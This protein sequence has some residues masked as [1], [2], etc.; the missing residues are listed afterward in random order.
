[1]ENLC[2]ICREG[3]TFFTRRKIANNEVVCEDCLK[4]AKNLSLKQIAF[5]KTVTADEIRD[6]IIQSNVNGDELL[7]FKATNSIGK[8]VQFDDDNKKWLIPSK[9]TFIPTPD[10]IFN[11]SDIVDFELLEDGESVASGGLG[12][13]LVGGA[14]FGGVG[15][16]VGGVTGKR[17]S[18]NVCSSLRLK[19]TIN[20]M[21]SPAVYINFIET[22]T[23]K[24]GLS[25]KAIADQAQE[26]LSVF[27]LI[28][29]KQK[30]TSENMNQTSSAAE[31][32]RKFKEL[33]DDGIIT[34]E[35]FDKK[36]NE[37]LG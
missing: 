21:D 8:F 20:N 3:T 30:G 32:I 10:L 35:E 13:A 25:Y 4:K 28:C 15:A 26:C 24:D 37:L 7:A 36:K 19:V 12:R 34:Q 22:K 17:K 2:A 27:Q 31:E 5:L 1:M 29:D 16:I 14:L 6:S 33:L 9:G 18:K 23:Q 11:Y